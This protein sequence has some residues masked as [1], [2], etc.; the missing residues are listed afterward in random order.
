MATLDA[1]FGGGVLGVAPVGQKT[2]VRFVYTWVD[3]DTWSIAITSSLS[4][5]VTL[6]KGNIAGQTYQGLG[7]M[8]N[9]VFVGFENNFA[10]SAVTDPTQWEEHDIGTGVQSF[11]SQYGAQDTVQTFASYQGR[12][13]VFGSQS[14][15][16]WNFDA[17]PAAIT[18]DQILDN[19][20][21]ND[22]LSVQNIGDLDV[23][24]LDRS[25][26]RSIRSKELIRNA[27]VNDDGVAIDLIVREKLK[28]YTPGTAISIVE[29][30]TKHYWLWLDDTLFVR[31]SYPQSKILAWST[32][33]PALESEVNDTDNVAGGY[34]DWDAVQGATYYWAKGSNET[35]LG[36]NSG[37]GFVEL[38]T[39]SGGFE[40][41]EGLYIGTLT[42]RVYHTANE[43]RTGTVTRFDL[44]LTPRRFVVHNNQVYMLATD[45]KVYLYGGS[46][47][48]TYDHCRL[49]LETPWLNF[50]QASTFKQ[51]QGLDA[52]FKGNWE[53][54]ASANPRATSMTRVISRGVSDP[55]T[56]AEDSTFDI[57]HFGYSGHGTHVKMRA[58]SF[59]DDESKLGRVNILYSDSNVK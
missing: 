1:V 31:A 7:K 47:N 37:S 42:I 13:V 53:V 40:V 12:L 11:V 50:G 29:P 2:K 51:Y 25:G 58:E 5:N 45:G 52:A 36:Y 30:S 54:F 14:I 10:F 6:G 8:R 28:T 39:T 3:G 24:F 59:D 38:R 20:G 35:R 49:R 26:V 23:L 55:P 46:D 56:M 27:Y 19:T 41:P 34:T 57:G 32:Y 21:T 15:Q 18:L 22:P 4:G 33:K 43:P 16:T 48:D 9:R 44:P 17:D